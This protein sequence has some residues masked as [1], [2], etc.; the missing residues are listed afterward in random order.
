MIFT[1]ADDTDCFYCMIPKTRKI[2]YNVIMFMYGWR[3]F[4]FFFFWGVGGWGGGLEQK[5]FFFPFFISIM[6]SLIPTVLTLLTFDWRYVSMSKSSL[7]N[8]NL[9][10]VKMIE[11]HLPERT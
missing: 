9:S 11:F 10:N 7:P 8:V 5:K 6:L 3:C 1:I 4:T 2:Y